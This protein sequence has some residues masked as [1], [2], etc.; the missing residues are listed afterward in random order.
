[1]HLS[2]I[3]QLNWKYCVEFFNLWMV[4]MYYLDLE[5]IRSKM[6]TKMYMTSHMVDLWPT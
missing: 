3:L 4:K 6:N 1:M 2:V 5:A